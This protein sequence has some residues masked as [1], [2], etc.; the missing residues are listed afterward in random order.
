MSFLVDRYALRGTC[1]TENIEQDGQ[2]KVRVVGPCYHCTKPITVLADADGWYKFEAGAYV[3]D[4]LPTLSADDREFLI[5]G[6]CGEC[7]NKMF[8]PEEE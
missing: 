2:E 6:I 8:P 5:S 4:C 1:T 7:W 3:Q